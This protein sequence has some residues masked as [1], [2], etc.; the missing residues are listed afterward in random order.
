MNFLA[1]LWLAGEDEGLKLGALLGDF[2]RGSVDNPQVPD[3]AKRG[4]LL[5][6]F[7]D[8]HIDALPEIAALREQF[9]PPFRRYS[10]III[11]LAFDHE[12]ARNWQQ[13]SVISL[14]AYDQDIRALLALHDAL[15]PEDL[16]RF[17][18]YADRRGLFESYRDE[19]EILHSLRG[20]GRR[21]SRDNPL[22]RVDEIWAGMKPAFE[23]S[24]KTVF[25]VIQRDV[26]NW[27]QPFPD[28]A[29]TA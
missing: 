19:Q 4:I 7:I 23:A 12:L 5:H 18:R 17:M 2:I 6:R 11:D 8:Q 13:F 24:F 26:A 22:D 1:H 20:V 21:L 15:L 28:T 16:R 10:G 25:P 3:F 27:L 29:A 9:E 14:A